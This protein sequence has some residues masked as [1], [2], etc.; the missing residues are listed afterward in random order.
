[1]PHSPSTAAPASVALLSDYEEGA[2]V[3][4]LGAGTTRRT[5]IMENR[6]YKMM[7]TLIIYIFYSFAT[8]GLLDPDHAGKSFK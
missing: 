6:H 3:E 8:G 7:R 1:M 4:V 5:T 2:V